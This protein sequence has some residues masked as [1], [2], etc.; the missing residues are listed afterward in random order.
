M[1]ESTPVEE[2]LYDTD[3]EISIEVAT[4]H[5]L[6]LIDE[7][8]GQVHVIVNNSLR[9]DESC[10]K[11]LSHASD[12]KDFDDDSIQSNALS[13][14][15]DYKHTLPYLQDMNLK[16]STYE[17]KF[18]IATKAE[19]VPCLENARKNK[20]LIY[21]ASGHII[22]PFDYCFKLFRLSSNCHQCHL[23]SQKAILD[24]IASRILQSKL[25]WG[26]PNPKSESLNPTEKSITDK[27]EDHPT[28]NK[29]SFTLI[30]EFLSYMNELKLKHVTISSQR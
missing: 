30:S 28:E 23:T 29:S 22:L 3:S 13:L 20:K 18:V 10:A 21:I 2:P 15:D 4:E 26:Y 17:K 27:V 5:V 11:L 12:A 7:H 8:D 6:R 25:I 16:S 1:I 24:V 9:H 19:V 14:G